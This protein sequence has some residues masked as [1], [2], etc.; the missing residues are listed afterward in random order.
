ME[1]LSR[2]QFVV[3]AG[4]GAPTA[5]FLVACGGDG[6]GTDAEDTAD[7]SVDTVVLGEEDVDGELP[8]TFSVV[9]RWFPTWL[10]PG[11]L[12]LPVSLSDTDGILPVGPPTIL[13]RILNAE[14][15]DVVVTDI[16][17]VRRVVAPGTVPYWVFETDI[18]E[19]G[20]YALQVLGGDVDGAALQVL[21]P[22]KV[23]IGKPGDALTPFDTPTVDDGRGVD[24][25]CTLL[26]EPCPFHEVTLTEA[27]ASGKPVALLVGTPAHC[28]TG[29]CSPALEALVELSTEYTDRFVFVHAEIFT[30][31][32]ATITT[33][34]VK[35][36]GMDYEPSLFVTDATGTVVSRLDAVFNGDEIRA[37]LDAV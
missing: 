16:E 24:P 20:I 9:Q 2:R 33:P 22:E 31:D 12:R 11:T 17:G 37:V 26:P 30:D 25:I 35:F 14:T 36:Y 7:D 34:F 29:T 1:S 32:T 19:P 8:E 27:L 3:A 6:G 13:G 4:L 18:D 28:Q 5:L 23:T 10:V 21:E 15:G